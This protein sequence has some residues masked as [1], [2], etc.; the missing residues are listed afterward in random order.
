MAS[1]TTSSSVAEKGAGWVGFAGVILAISG[2]LHI[3]DGLWVLDHKD[4]AGGQI[5]ELLYETDLETWGWIYLIGGIIV[6]IAGFAV[7]GRA[8]WARWVG[9]LVASV[10]IILNM[11]WA[12][13][14]PIQALLVIILDALVIYAL[15][16]YA[17]RDTAQA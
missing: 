14:F 12:F 4:T 17:G 5:S 3:I 1:T 10:S 8:Q 11:A 9:I 7:L 16:V 15:V 6:L 13:A 2:A